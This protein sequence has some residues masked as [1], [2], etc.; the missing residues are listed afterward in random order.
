MVFSKKTNGDKARG[1]G[2]P[3]VCVSLDN[4]SEGVFSQDKMAPPLTRLV[5]LALNLSP[6]ACLFQT[7]LR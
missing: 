7:H 5:H 3:G 4:E 2:R 1:G 6:V